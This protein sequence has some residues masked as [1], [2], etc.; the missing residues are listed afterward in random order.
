MPVR[1]GWITLSLPDAGGV[2]PP[3]GRDR[4]AAVHAERLIVALDTGMRHLRP[5]KVAASGVASQPVAAQPVAAQPVAA[6]LR[7]PWPDPAALATYCNR[8]IP[9]VAKSDSASACGWR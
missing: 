4:V 1:S 3:T 6:R 2:L 7:A 5:Q 8:I 9:T